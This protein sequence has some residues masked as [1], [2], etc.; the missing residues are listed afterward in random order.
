MSRWYS[1]V[2]SA[3]AKDKRAGVRRNHE[4]E[5]NLWS[6]GYKSVAEQKAL[7]RLVDRDMRARLAAKLET[8]RA[9]LDAWLSG[10]NPM[11]EVVYAAVVCLLRKG[12]P[13]E[14]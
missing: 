14:T 11:P 1:D 4:A 8:S 2:V 5:A 3:S 10:R 12:S 13:K 6:R 9:Q 7:G